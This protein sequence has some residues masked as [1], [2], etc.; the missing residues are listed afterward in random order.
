MKQEIKNLIKR[1]KEESYRQIILLVLAAIFFIILAWFIITNF[2]FIIKNIN[3]A[4]NTSFDAQ[5]AS[6]KFDK[7]GFEQLNL[8]R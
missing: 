2:I 7:E 5:E 1:I 8:V 3:Q 6:L 4:F